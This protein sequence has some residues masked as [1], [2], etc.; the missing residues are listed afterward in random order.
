MKTETPSTTLVIASLCFGEFD[1]TA[2]Q[3][4]RAAGYDLE[5]QHSHAMPGMEGFDDVFVTARMERAKLSE[6]EDKL[7]NQLDAIMGERGIVVCV[8]IFENPTPEQRKY[9]GHYADPVPGE[10]DNH[11]RIAPEYRRI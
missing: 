3:E 9:P 1:L 8:D 2:L 5:I 6:E 7:V 11:C 10:D 4:L